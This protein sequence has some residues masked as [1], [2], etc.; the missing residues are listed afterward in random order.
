MLKNYGQE[1]VYNYLK[2]L[3]LLIVFIVLLLLEMSGTD[4]FAE[5]HYFLNVLYLC[6]P[7]SQ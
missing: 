2:K 5:A 1:L 3:S 6:P 7:T 4:F